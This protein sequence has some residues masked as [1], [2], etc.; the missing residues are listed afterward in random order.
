M[1]LALNKDEL[2]EALGQFFVVGIQG[3]TLDKNE[4]KLL[5]ELQPGGV[6]LFK[7]NYSSLRQIWDLNTQ[8]HSILK[9][10]SYQQLSPWICVDQEGGRVQRLS[11]IHI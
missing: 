7:R 9:K 1:S 2:A 8:L 5:E 6:I 4:Q 10:I 3:E 11:L